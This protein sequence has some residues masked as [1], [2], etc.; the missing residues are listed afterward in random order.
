MPRILPTVLKN[1]F[2]KPATLKYPKV[3]RELPEG[4]RGAPTIDSSL[5]V[6][7]WNCIRACP[8]RA[9][10]VKKETRTP[11]INLT[12]C[13]QC[14]ECAEACPTKAIRMSKEYELA[15]VDKEAAKAE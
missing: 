6:R 15:V 7:C 8:V 3:K 4:Y 11:S 10:S 9:I 1:L 12:M 14:G 2:R 13:I 5:C